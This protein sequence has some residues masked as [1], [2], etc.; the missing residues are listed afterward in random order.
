M[1]WNELMS[2]V[3]TWVVVPAYKWIMWGLSLCEAL[4]LLARASPYGEIPGALLLGGR[5]SVASIAITRTFL[6]GWLLLILGAL[7]RTAAYRELG[8]FTYELSLRKE[9]RLVTTGPYAF[10]R[11][12]SY[13]GLAM[14]VVGS[15]VCFWGPGSWFWE[16][17][18][19]NYAV[20]R[21]IAWGW[22]TIVGFSSVN[23]LVLRPGLEDQIMEK[24]F[25]EEWRE[26]A[27]R[28]TP[29]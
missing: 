17:G 14:V 28:A 9:H 21:A 24:Q 19:V 4:A 29:A 18:A 5:S 25:G 13:P 8:R 11:H 1:T 12:P 10:V 27:T 2:E 3:L 23:A 22:V 15:L 26:Y 6:A 16:C 7:V 20:G